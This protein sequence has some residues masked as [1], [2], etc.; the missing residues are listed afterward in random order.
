MYSDAIYS[1]KKLSVAQY[2]KIIKTFLYTRW[3]EKKKG[4]KD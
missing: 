4:L 3:D 1:V 2:F